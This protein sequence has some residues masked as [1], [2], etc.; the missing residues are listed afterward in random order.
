VGTPRKEARPLTRRDWYLLFLA[1]VLGP[2]V[3]V[4]IP[5]LYLEWTCSEDVRSFV[6]PDGTY[7]ALGVARGC[8]GAAGSVTSSVRV[9]RADEPDT[10]GETVL[11]AGIGLNMSLSWLDTRTLVID[12][13]VRPERAQYVGQVIQ[14][15]SGIMVIARPR[16]R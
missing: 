12:Y 9:R 7:V 14:P 10:T 6:S 16:A 13:A 15:R 8:G 4:G 3:L 1:A 2:I 5:A 11:N